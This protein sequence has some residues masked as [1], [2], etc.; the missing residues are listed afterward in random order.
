[1]TQFP[2]VV[3]MSHKNY[4]IF[5][6]KN[7]HINFSKNLSFCITYKAYNKLSIFFLILD[8]SSRS[9]TDCSGTY[10]HNISVVESNDYD[11]N[12]HIDAVPFKRTENR[13]RALQCLFQVPWL[14][15]RFVR[16][17]YVC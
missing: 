11:H 12:T 8:N 13:F 17:G 2:F 10:V 14:D 7:F 6:F 15:Y 9:Y 5:D 16:L 3:A 4:L 1:M